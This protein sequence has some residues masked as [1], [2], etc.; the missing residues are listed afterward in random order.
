MRCH[1][2]IQYCSYYSKTLVHGMCWRAKALI[3]QMTMQTQSKLEKCK[4][5]MWPM[6]CT[7]E[8][9]ELTFKMYIQ[10]KLKKCN[11]YNIYCCNHVTDEMPGEEHGH[12]HQAGVLLPPCQP[13]LS[14]FSYK[15]ITQLL[16]LNSSFILRDLRWVEDEGALHQPRAVEADA[17]VPE[18]Y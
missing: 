17:Q 2:C 4:T 8:P 1:V 3:L 7:W 14:R 6:E 5:T 10:H 11:I 16:L 15:D 9:R 12:Q 18:D 13:H